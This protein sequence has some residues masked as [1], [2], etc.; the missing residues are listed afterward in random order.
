MRQDIIDDVRKDYE[1]IGKMIATN[2]SEMDDKDVTVGR[3]KKIR[4]IKNLYWQWLSENLD[5][6]DCVL[7]KA[8]KDNRA[9]E[10]IGK[11]NNILMYIAEMH[12]GTYEKLFD[13]NELNRNPDE[14]YVLYVDIENEHRY[15]VKKEE[16][17]EFEKTHQVIVTYKNP[18]VNAG[19]N[20]EK[21]YDEIQSVK[22]EFIRQAMYSTQE[23]ATKQ[24]IKKYPVTDKVTIRY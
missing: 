12:Y 11:T 24:F 15:M 8:I 20:F 7:K 5:I 14:L 9:D 19:W 22:N 18:N 23:E 2:F 16:Q 10:Y 17:E 4:K 3:Y 6:D 21:N 13:L 1:D